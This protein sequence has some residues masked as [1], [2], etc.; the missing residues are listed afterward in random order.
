MNSRRRWRRC[1]GVSLLEE[2]VTGALQTRRSAKWRRS[3]AEHL[4][5]AAEP[6]RGAVALQRRRLR[7]RQLKRERTPLLPLIETQIEAQRLQWQA[8]GLQVRA[9]GEPVA[10]HVDPGK[11]GTV[12]GSLLSNAI[13]F[14]ERGG[15]IAF[16]VAASADTVFIDLQDAGPGVAPGDRERVFEPFCGERQPER[17][18]GT[19]IGLSIVQEYIAAHG[20][21]I[22]LLLAVPWPGRALPHQ[23][24][25]SP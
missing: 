9:E 25:R 7:A 1:A 24:A 13:R 10:V 15:T 17:R 5:G 16:T 20:G 21:R 8:Q 19:G 6:D 14:S 2:G 18:Q 11:L 23:V 12:I 22:E 3:Q 4:R